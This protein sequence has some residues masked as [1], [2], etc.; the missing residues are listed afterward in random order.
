[1]DN[2]LGMGIVV[3]CAVVWCGVVWDGVL[4]TYSTYIHTYIQLMIMQLQIHKVIRIDNKYQN[5][6][7]YL[8]LYIGKSSGLIKDT[9]ISS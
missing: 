9:Y 8:L 7:L 4:Y 3:C 5:T 2:G 1:M 6:S